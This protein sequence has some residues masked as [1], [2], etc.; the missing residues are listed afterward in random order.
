MI[1]APRTLIVIVVSAAL[2][3]APGCSARAGT[4]GA[5]AD[6]PAV[7]STPVGAWG[8]PDAPDRPSLVIDADGSFTGSDSC[9]RLGGSWREENGTVLL[10]DTFMT[11]MACLDERDQWLSSART[12]VVEGDELKG[13]DEA[14]T[15]IG[16][17]SRAG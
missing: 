17:L 10:E 1:R 8:E 14:G 9:N 12:L 4:T 16:T 11:T 5:D 13:F 6:D 7:S 3:I 2:L 15:P